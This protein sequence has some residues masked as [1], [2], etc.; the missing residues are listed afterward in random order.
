[1]VNTLESLFEINESAVSISIVAL[2]FPLLTVEVNVNCD[3][4]CMETAIIKREKK[5]KC[6]YT[7]TMYLAVYAQVCRCV[8]TT[9]KRRKVYKPQKTAEFI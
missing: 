4:R 1:M 9:M 3:V 2:S 5:M 7:G 6:T 8:N